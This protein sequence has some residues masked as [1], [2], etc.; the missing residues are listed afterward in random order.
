MGHTVS[1]QRMI[2]DIMLKELKDF[3]KALREE[4]R[5]IYLDLIKLP[6]K[7]VGAIS[8]ASSVNAWAFLILSILIEM[9]KNVA[10]GR[11]QKREQDSFVDQDK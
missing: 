6:L 11:I 4:D 2:I 1:S 8:Y 9:Q 3:A 10:D 7:R 5:K